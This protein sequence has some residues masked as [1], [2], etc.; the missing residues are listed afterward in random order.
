MKCINCYREIADGLKFCPKCGF[1]QPD[2]RAAYELEHPELA[3]AM[4]EDEI[5]EQVNMLADE[6]RTAM[7]RDE[8]VQLIASD[9]NYK[10][11]A[12]IVDDGLVTY[13][14]IEP[15]DIET[16]YAKCA[17]LINDKQGFYPYFVKLLSQ[18]PEKARNLLHNQVA[19][20]MN[21]AQPGVNNNNM[22]TQMPEV[23]KVT[24]PPHP[25]IPSTP[26]VNVPAP[27]V[28]QNTMGM[29]P[30]PPVTSQATGNQEMM[31]CP[32]CHQLIA[33]GTPQCP[34]CKQILD[35]SYSTTANEEEASS[36]PKKGVWKIALAVIAVLLIFG[37]GHLI[38]TLSQGPT[39]NPRKDAMRAVKEMIDLI[40]DADIST[41]EDIEKL[42]DDIEDLQYKYE[43]YY[44]KR[45]KLDEFKEEIYELESD[46]EIRRRYEKAFEELQRKMEKVKD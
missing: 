24:P 20:E 13:L 2:D 8:F 22:P 16:W 38:Y 14:L 11:I 18:Q 25:V 45:G 35:W 40:E 31:E 23:R 17:E 34:Y 26:Q 21:I 1:K 39:G 7:S 36:K 12:N 10:S 29:T 42:E 5:L 33:L 28:Q 6:P 32:I 15:N 43:K 27:P 4:P 37:A 9:P 3:D 46:S 41:K 44:S 30:Q 19:D